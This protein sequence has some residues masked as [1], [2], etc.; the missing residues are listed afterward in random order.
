MDKVFGEDLSDDRR[1]GSVI[2]D[3]RYRLKKRLGLP[4]ANN[5]ASRGLRT[6]E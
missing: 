1:N 5:P 2:K 4:K 3:R 6:K